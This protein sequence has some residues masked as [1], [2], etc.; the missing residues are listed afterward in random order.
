MW[1]LALS[2]RDVAVAPCA[3]AELPA[4]SASERATRIQRRLKVVRVMAIEPI[5]VRRRGCCE[6]RGAAVAVRTRPSDGAHR[7]QLPRAYDRIQSLLRAGTP[8]RDN[9]MGSIAAAS[10][11]HLPPDGGP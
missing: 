9:S 1:F 8:R 2:L 7:P 11:R 10:D 5:R 6:V 4:S 3:V